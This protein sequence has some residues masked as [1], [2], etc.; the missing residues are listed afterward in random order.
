MSPRGVH[1]RSWWQRVRLAWPLLVAWTVR[2]LKARYRQS[3]LSALWS[4]VQPAALLVTYG[5]VFTTI[6]NVRTGDIPFLSFAWSGLC[7]F[8]FAQH[9]LGAG[10]SV[11]TDSA[12]LISKTYF[13]RE[14]LPL[15][16]VG[17]GLADL[18]VSVAILVGVGWVQTGPPG[19]HALGALASLGVL[20]LVVSG[21]TLCASAVSVARRDLQHAMPLLLRVLFILTPVFYPLSALTTAQRRGLQI[22]PLT[23]V[24]EG[25]RDGL[26]RDRWPDA[27][28]LAIHATAGAVLVVIGL[29]A[30]RRAERLMADRA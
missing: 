27:S 22:N 8:S 24:V 7:V 23:V 16:V 9:C 25:V 19:I 12:H 28:L 5:W 3:W 18:G 4:L 21:V 6:L 11:F 17:V 1:Y 20:V 13:P 29:Y 26:L 2:A 10:V 30:V 15:S 14:V